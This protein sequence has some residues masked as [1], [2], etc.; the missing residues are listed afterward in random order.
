M[1]AFKTIELVEVL[2]PRCEGIHYAKKESC[3]KTKT[4]HYI[5]RVFCTGNECDGHNGMIWKMIH[6]PDRYT[7]GVVIP[8]TYEHPIKRIVP[9]FEY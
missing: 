9:E 2:C 5:C 6:G 7:V 4:D 3:E 8:E 1:M